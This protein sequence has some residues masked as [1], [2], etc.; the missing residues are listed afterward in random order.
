M[1]GPFPGRAESSV[2]G[3]YCPPEGGVPREAAP[4]AGADGAARRSEC[5]PGG[6]SDQSI[7]GAMMWAK[8]FRAR[9]NRLFTVPR[10]QEVMSA[11]SSYVFPSISRSTKTIR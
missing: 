2:V 6:G 9:F 10:L 4:P 5:P 7:M 8:L 3:F 11:I 1:P